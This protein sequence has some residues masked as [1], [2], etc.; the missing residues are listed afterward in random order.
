VENLLT[1]SGEPTKLINCSAH[2]KRKMGECKAVKLLVNK[3]SLQSILSDWDIV[4]RARSTISKWAL[5]RRALQHWRSIG[6]L[7]YTKW[8]ENIYLAD[9]FDRWTISD[10]TPGSGTDSNPIESFNKSLKCNVLP[11]AVSMQTFL[12]RPLQSLF[13]LVDLNYSAAGTRDHLDPIASMLTTP[14]AAEHLN[15]A[16]TLLCFRGNYI[17]KNFLSEENPS[18]D[19]QYWLFNSTRNL[20]ASDEHDDPNHITTDKADSFLGRVVLGTLPLPDSYPNME[21]ARQSLSCYHVVQVSRCP[22]VPS[23]GLLPLSVCTKK[24]AWNC[25]CYDYSRNGLMCSHVLCTLHLKKVADVVK[26]NSKLPPVQKGRPKKDSLRKG[27][28]NGL[29]IQPP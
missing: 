18:S 3:D 14:T 27:R 19:Q 20:V 22:G 29:T 16:C 7:N 6:E 2:L 23:N 28:Q 11:E 26:M 12:G 1:P 24:L 10:S 21:K 17:C 5:I 4:Y 8:F 25:T 13:T 9:D 15:K